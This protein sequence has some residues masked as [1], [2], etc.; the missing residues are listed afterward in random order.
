M[1]QD[2]AYRNGVLHAEEVP[3][4]RIAEAVGTPFYCYSTAALERHYRLFA[5]AFADQRAT[6]CYSIKANGNLAVIRTF[7]EHGA[8]ADVVS[9][10]ELKRA[11]AA[12]IPADR[13][14]FSGVGKTKAE[15]AA[16]LAA[17]IM[18]FNLE[19]EDELA[20]LNEIA[21]AQG[22]VAPVA[23]RINPDVDARTHDKIATGRATDKF[24]IGW[25]EAREVYR[26]A[27]ALPGVRVTGIAIHIGSQLTDLEPLEA[28]FRAV[29][30]ATGILRGDGHAITHV[31]LGGGLGIPY[32]FD[33]AT[34]APLETPPSPADYAALIA[35][36]TASLDCDIIVEPGRSLV[37]NAGVL[38][39]EVLVVKESRGRTFAVIDAAMNDLLRPA[40]YGAHHE[41]VPL[42]HT[43]AA[44]Q[45]IDVVG[46]IC[47]SSDVLAAGRSLARPEPGSLCAILSAGA[48]G[49][50]QSSG[51]NAR[52]LV[53][54]V[55][56]SGGRFAVVRARPTIE[57]SMAGE[58]MPPWLE[59]PSRSARGAA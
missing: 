10:G 3:L 34:I 26:R 35:R 38:V 47:E 8:G 52:P 21:V 33:H 11:L 40:L 53:P 41:I 56:V 7:A 27:A 55:L 51:Y 1:F 29:V 43:D 20:Q 12:S 31:D 23:V 15:M 42:L 17:G 58:S 48:Y 9:G 28:A 32:H 13:I 5:A 50:V 25:P 44:R 37:G 24:G 22:A 59:A 30:E 16:A 4:A 18:Q 45:P 57:E 19:S 36:T 46:P 39:S 14:V 6:I 49:A 2:F 54:E